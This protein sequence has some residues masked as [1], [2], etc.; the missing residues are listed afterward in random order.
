MLAWVGARKNRAHRGGASTLAARYDLAVRAST[1][2]REA[3]HERDEDQRG[4]ADEEL[5]PSVRRKSSAALASSKPAATSLD[6]LDL[7]V[8]CHLMECERE[9]SREKNKDDEARAALKPAEASRR[10]SRSPC[11]KRAREESGDGDDDMELALEGLA[12]SPSPPSP[13]G[14]AQ[15][16]PHTASS[17]CSPPE[18]LRTPGAFTLPSPPRKKVKPGL[19]PSLA[20]FASS[21]GRSWTTLSLDAGLDAGLGSIL[22]ARRTRPKACRSLDFSIPTLSESAG[23]ERGTQLSSQDEGSF[24]E[25]DAIDVVMSHKYGRPEDVM[26]VDET[27]DVAAAA[28]DEADAMDAMDAMEEDAENRHL[29]AVSLVD[30]DTRGGSVRQSARVD[31]GALMEVMSAVGGGR[32][33]ASIS[34]V[35]WRVKL[36]QIEE[37]IFII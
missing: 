11:V 24:D 34:A 30:V 1:S 32:T 18:Q 13:F 12:L 20:P 17:P 23:A 19:A 26:D 2:A 16:R 33:N 4:C 21:P 22:G 25:K 15:G 5:R 29:R 3:K 37:E 14:P 36:M 8:L 28:D 31:R 10:A 7:H 35:P 9:S 6:V 27:D